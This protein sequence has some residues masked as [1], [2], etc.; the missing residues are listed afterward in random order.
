VQ[1]I[2]DWKRREIPECRVNSA[3]LSLVVSILLYAE[4]MTVNPHCQPGEEE[5]LHHGRDIVCKAGFLPSQSM[6]IFLTLLLFYPPHLRKCQSCSAKLSIR[7]F[8][9]VSTWHLPGIAVTHF[10][11]CP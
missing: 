8:V 11:P 1:V 10:K 6:L 3:L 5:E 9:G 7:D 4:T 2:Q